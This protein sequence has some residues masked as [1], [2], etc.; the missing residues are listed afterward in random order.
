MSR[1][2]R[3]MILP[4]RA[5]GSSAAKTMS[6]GRA[7]PVPA[8]PAGPRLA[9]PRAPGLG[10]TP[11]LVQP[12]GIDAGERLGGRARL[13][14]GP[15]GQRRDEDVAGL[16]LPPRVYHGAAAAADDLPVPNPRLGIDR[17]TDA[18]EQPQARQAATLPGLLA[19]L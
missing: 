14:H 9:D 10:L 17:L 16:R 4:E 3:R 1:L 18:A 6:G 7:P 2:R 8:Q 15:A 5:F 11:P 12:R 19:P 13:E